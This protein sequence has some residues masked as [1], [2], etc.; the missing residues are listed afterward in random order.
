M[1]SF[2]TLKRLGF[3]RA[4]ALFAVISS[5]VATAQDIPA[6]PEVTTSALAVPAPAME[7][8][9]APEE[10]QG[11]GFHS[12]WAYLTEEG[13][14]DGTAWIMTP[15]GP[16]AVSGATVTVSA[17]G[18][19]VASTVSDENGQYAIP[20]LSGGIFT[21]ETKAA[22]ACG[23]ISARLV[24]N[25]NGTSSTGMD[26]Y[27]ASMQPAQLESIIGSMWVP[28]S[29]AMT[30]SRQVINQER[31]GVQTYRVRRTNGLVQGQLLFPVQNANPMGHVI[32]VYSGGQLV[33]ETTSDQQARFTLSTDVSGPV[34]I[35]VGGPSYAAIG[36]E[37]VN[38]ATEM[39]EVNGNSDVRFVSTA[40]KT[41]AVVQAPVLYIPVVTQF[42]SAPSEE[43]I[44]MDEAPLPLGA[45]PAPGFAGGGGGFAGGG[46]GFGGGG[47]G[48][49]GAA[50]LAGLAGLAVG[51]TALSDDDDGFNLN[52]ASPISN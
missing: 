16:K 23:A 42:P 28:V 10:A 20:G 14:L 45:A 41:A 44:V 35:I 39:T 31:P 30:G 49:G 22:D 52:Q 46:G 24:P 38:E 9:P 15:T 21:V 1:S 25:M 3:G 6:V 4:A 17:G 18:Q 47:G 37:I 43:V 5:S 11:I 40:V 29:G 7:S 19:M 8:V 13:Q 50:G 26:V 2:Q 51:I 32:R 12:G 48:L 27:C 36:A 34:D 33:E